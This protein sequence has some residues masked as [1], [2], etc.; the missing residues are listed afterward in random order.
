MNKRLIAFFSIL[1]L[2]V[3]LP[4]I[5][6][7][8]ADICLAEYPDSSWTDK[9]PENLKL[10]KDLLLT[11]VSYKFT[12]LNGKV[13]FKSANYATS[14]NSNSVS[15]TPI[16]EWFVNGNPINYKISST[17]KVEYNYVYSGANCTTRNINVLVPFPFTNISSIDNTNPNYSIELDK[18]FSPNGLKRYENSLNFLQ[19]AYLKQG[20]Q[21]LIILISNT[22]ANPFNP[23][24]LKDV[25]AFGINEQLYGLYSNKGIDIRA[26]LFYSRPLEFSLDNCIFTGDDSDPTKFKSALINND[27]VFNANNSSSTCKTNV[28]MQNNEDKWLDLGVVYYLNPN[29]KAVKNSKVIITCV[30][31]KTIKKVSGINPKCP[32]GYKV[33]A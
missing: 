6:A 18:V 28:Y 10:N 26:G 25:G 30:K 8:A 21:D 32:G 23:T 27:S 29:F 33:K 1:S 13:Q 9:A 19:K 22:K 15:I 12:D 31:G 4:L 17:T 7:K 3:S 16:Q 11:Q 20:I 24:A 5:T 2:S 14:S